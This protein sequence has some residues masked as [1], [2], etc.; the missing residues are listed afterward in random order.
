[1]GSSYGF[2]LGVADLI[3]FVPQLLCEA[4]AT[5][6]DFAQQR[7]PSTLGVADQAIMFCA[8]SDR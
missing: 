3:D 1:L 4:C 7:V 8:N 6:L 2:Q 5:A